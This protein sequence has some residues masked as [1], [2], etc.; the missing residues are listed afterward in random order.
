MKPCLDIEEVE[1][2]LRAGWYVRLHEKALPNSNLPLTCTVAPVCNYRGMT[3]AKHK[4]VPQWLGWESGQ[5]KRYLRSVE[6]ELASVLGPDWR[7]K[8][9]D[10]LDPKPPS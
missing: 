5:R 4:Q 3:N 10:D 2:R 8:V 1:A 9:A 6:Q 7:Q